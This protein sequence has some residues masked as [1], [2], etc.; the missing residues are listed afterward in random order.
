MEDD[1]HPH[2]Q[3]EENLHDDHQLGLNG[4]QN[5]HHH[6]VESASGVERAAWK[7]RRVGNDDADQAMA[8]DWDAAFDEVNDNY[9]LQPFKRFWS[10]KHELVILKHLLRFAE[11]K[12]CKPSGVKMSKFYVYLKK[13][14][15]DLDFDK[16]QLGD[17]VRKM[18]IKFE[19]KMRKKPDS[20]YPDKRD[21]RIFQLSKE[22]WGSEMRAATKNVTS[23]PEESIQKEFAELVN[24]MSFNKNSLLDGLAM[25]IETPMKAELV[26]N[27]QILHAEYFRNRWNIEE[28]VFS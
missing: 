2:L 11:K 10:Q 13:I 21:Q 7:R 4:N 28:K 16:I 27:W 8:Q 24:Q 14:I 25:M 26:R 15:T 3:N 19:N 18:K 12:K 6:D 20:V 9:K 1:L 17:K 23:R 5:N 22:I